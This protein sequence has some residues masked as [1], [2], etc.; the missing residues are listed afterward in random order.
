MRA[1]LAGDAPAHAELARLQA[2]LEE[3]SKALDALGVGPQALDAEL[4]RLRAILA[5]PSQYLFVSRKS[6]R[7]DRLNV[8]A[9]GGAALDFDVA[10]VPG[11]PPLT[12]A[13]ALV[14]IPRSALAPP[15]QLL[16]DAARLL[17]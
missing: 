7:L 10:R 15:G 14:R 6:L 16:D 12:R 3:N 4:E 17:A 8:V 9:E 5:D 11:N 13:F 2:A 1:A